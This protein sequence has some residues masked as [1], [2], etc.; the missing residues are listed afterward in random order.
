MPLPTMQEGAHHL[1]LM[2]SHPD[3][4]SSVKQARQLELLHIKKWVDNYVS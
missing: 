1:D 2:Y 3:D 4:P